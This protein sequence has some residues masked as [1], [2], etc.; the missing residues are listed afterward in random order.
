MASDLTTIREVADV[1]DGPHATPT[2][3]EEGPYFLSI[4]SLCGGK[5]DLTQSAHLSEAEFTKWTRRVTPTKGDVLFSYETR[6]GEAAMMPPNVRACLGRRMG[7]LRPKLGR[8]IPEYLLYA[9]LAPAFQE[10]IRRRTI[11]G[12][13]VPRIA[14]KELPDFPIR[15]PVAL[16]E[17][18]QVVRVLGTLDDK[19]ELNR[20]MNQTLEAIAQAIFKSWFV[21]F[22][23]V[24]AKAAAAA[25]GKSATEIERAAMA[26]ISGKPETELDKLSEAQCQSLA[27]TAALFPAAFIDSEL[28]EIPE[29]WEM[30]T[31]GAETE[32]VGGATPSTKNPKFWEGGEH[33][34]VTPKDFSSLQNK[35][36]LS[37]SRRITDEGLERIS[38]GTLPVETVLMSS[39]APVGYLAITKIETAVNQGFIAMK[40]NGRLP[41]EYVLLWADSLMAQIKQAASGSTFAEISKKTFRPFRIIVPISAVLDTFAA[42]VSTFYER[43]AANSRESETLAQLRDTLLPRLLSGEIELRDPGYE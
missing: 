13:T 1:F 16:E 33:H 37:S 21:D 36:L 6:L 5:F 10:E 40:C 29:G 30:S 22:D 12:S 19:I 34:W 23:P 17:Q 31:I 15:I 8:V 3:T 11:P 38:S 14:L 9:Y 26:A 32:T 20:R 4:S 39:R 2:K 41:P 7:L 18:R 35:V 25:A 28:G 43:I 27:E 42:H 24:K